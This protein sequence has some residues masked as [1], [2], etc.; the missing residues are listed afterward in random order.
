MLDNE[1]SNNNENIHKDMSRGKRE[2]SIRKTADLRRR[3]K[4]K[5]ER[6][7]EGRKRDDGEGEGEEASLAESY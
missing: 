6:E 7:R 1:L 5:K 2:E 4:K 3:L